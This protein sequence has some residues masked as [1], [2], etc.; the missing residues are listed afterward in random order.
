MKFVTDHRFIMGSSHEVC[1]DY[2]FADTINGIPYASSSS[3][4]ATS[5]YLT[6]SGTTLKALTNANGAN[7]IIEAATLDP[8]SRAFAAMRGRA[9]SQDK[10]TCSSDLRQWQASRQP[11]ARARP[12]GT[13]LSHA[14]FQSRM[15]RIGS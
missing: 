11:G 1:E 4:L 5:T 3:V 6:W 12:C 14:D 7:S 15:T 9:A 2:A 13:S 8:Y 10:Q